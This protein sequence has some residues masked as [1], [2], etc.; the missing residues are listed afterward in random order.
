[1]EDLRET[2]LNGSR[3]KKMLASTVNDNAKIKNEHSAIKMLPGF[4][5]SVKLRCGKS[6]C[7]CSRGNRH[8]GYYHVTYS[9]GV[10]LRRYVR[11]DQVSKLREACEAHRALQAQLRAGRAEYKKTLGRARELVIMLRNE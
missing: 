11:R 6:N 2:K 4:I 10:R 7:R 9:S 5:A 1:M 3:G 8:V